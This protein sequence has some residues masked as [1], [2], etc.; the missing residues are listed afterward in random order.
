[1]VEILGNV[2]GQWGAF[3]HPSCYSS[4]TLTDKESQRNGNEMR[5]GNMPSRLHLALKRKNELPASE[6]Q[7]RWEQCKK[8]VKSKTNESFA[9]I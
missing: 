8:E 2:E 6:Y 3:P 4:A 7:D 9:N 1:M 5:K